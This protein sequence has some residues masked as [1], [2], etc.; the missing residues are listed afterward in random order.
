MNQ[1]INFIL[2][3]FVLGLGGI[4]FAHPMPSSMVVLKVHE[5]SI[6]GQIMLPLA[7]LQSAIGLEV[8]DKSEQLIERLGDSLRIYL[9]QHI[10]PR[11]FEGKAWV[12]QIG[13]L[14]VVESNDPIVGLYKELRI[15]FEMSP[16]QHYDLR[17][18]YFDYDVILHQVASHKT[19]IQV[20]Q[21]WQQGFVREDTTTLQI[22]VIEWDMING[23][24]N[25]FQVSLN[26]GSDWQGFKNMV[27]LGISHIKEGTDH[28]L[29]VLTLLFPALLVAQNKR[30]GG[31][32]GTKESGKNLLKIV[33][34]FTIGH[35][36]T[37][38]LGTIEWLN[39]P[40]QPIEI[41]IAITILISALHALVPIYPKKEV[42]IAGSFGLI[43]GLAFS[44]TLKNLELSTKQLLLSLLGFNVGIE[45]MQLFL[46]LLV[47]PLLLLLSKHDTT[48]HFVK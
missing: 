7:E 8:N 21:D 23:K 48:P 2:I 4:V 1:K 19:L 47:F 14:E 44:E 20:K 40:S 24:L 36:L 11:S 6:S 3:A 12:V 42:I 45:L 33:T 41:L 16:P 25:P 26:Q 35:S 5:K 22:G 46:I 13:E 34:A 18:F 30:W 27:S 43:H 39:F 37:L 38:I 28:L 31:V 17:N 29:F 32:A 9:R 10:R 15:N